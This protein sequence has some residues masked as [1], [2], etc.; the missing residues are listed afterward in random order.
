MP[1]ARSGNVFLKRRSQVSVI[2]CPRP[3]AEERLLRADASPRLST[4]IIA[5]TKSPDTA[6]RLAASS[7]VFRIVEI[8]VW[9]TVM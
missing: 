1:E 4:L 3:V 9:A 5:E 6:V 8:S 7:A 2:N